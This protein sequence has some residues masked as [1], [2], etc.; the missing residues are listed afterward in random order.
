[1]GSLRKMFKTRLPALATLWSASG[2]PG[3]AEE[4]DDP[5][6]AAELHSVTTHS[7]TS[8]G[9]EPTYGRAGKQPD[10][11]Y[12]LMRECPEIIEEVVERRYN[13]GTIV[14]PHL[15]HGLRRLSVQDVFE[16]GSLDARHADAESTE[17]GGGVDTAGA[18]SDEGRDR[19]GESTSDSGLSSGKGSDAGD[20]YAV[21]KSETYEVPRAAVTQPPAED[22]GSGSEG[23]PNGAETENWS[24][25]SVGEPSSDSDGANGGA[26]L[27]GC[28][29]ECLR[30]PPDENVYL[31][32]KTVEEIE[33]DRQNMLNG[34]TSQVAEGNS[35]YSGGVGQSFFL[36][37]P[38]TSGGETYSG[39]LSALPHKARSL[40]N[41]QQ[42]FI[43]VHN[44]E[45]LAVPS[46]D[47]KTHTR[48]KPNKKRDR[49]SKS[50][51]AAINQSINDNFVLRPSKQFET[52]GHG[53]RSSLSFR[54]SLY[55]TTATWDADRQPWDGYSEL[56]CP[57][58]APED[59]AEEEPLPSSR[60]S[61]LER[62]YERLPL[63]RHSTELQPSEPLYANSGELQQLLVQQLREQTQPAEPADQPDGPAPGMAHIAPRGKRRR[64]GRIT[65]PVDAA[66]ALET[67]PEHTETP[68]SPA[69][70]LLAL[71]T[72]DSKFA[73]VRIKPATRGR[74]T[75]R[76][77]SSMNDIGPVLFTPPPST[78]AHPAVHTRLPS[79]AES[80]DQQPLEEAPAAPAS[81][82]SAAPLWLTLG[83]LWVT[84]C[85]WAGA[86]GRALGR[87]TAPLS[88]WLGVKYMS[89]HR[90][91]PWLPDLVDQ[92]DL[93]YWIQRTKQGSNGF[94]ELRK[95]IKHGGDFCK[96][97]ASILQE[98]SDLEVTYARGLQKLAAKLLKASRDGLGS[99]NQAWQ[100]VGTEMEHQADIHKTLAVTY[101]EE[102]VKPLRGLLESQHK[103]RRTVETNVDK[104]A[105]NLA[106][107][108]SAEAKA[109][110]LS[111]QCARENERA[112]EQ[113]LEARLAHDSARK[114]AGKVESR[115][116]KT[117]NA[118]AKADTEYYNFCLRSERARLEWE[119]ALN[120]G[121][122]CFQRLEEERLTRLRAAL[123]A[124]HQSLAELAPKIAQSA[125]RLSEPVSGADVSQ[126][127]QT[128][129]QV[130]RPDQPAEQLLPDFYAEDMTNA[131]N[132]DRRKKA[133][134]QF[135]RLLEQDVGRERRGKSGVENLAKAMKESPQFS[136]ESSQKDVKEKLQHLRST[137][138]YLEAS[139]FKVQ[140]ALA[141]TEG[142]PRPQHP[143]SRHIQ[144][145]KDRQ[146][147][148]QSVLRVPNWVNLEPS[149]SSP[150]HSPAWSADRDRGTA[151]GTSQRPP[152]DSDELNTEDSPPEST[153]VSAVTSPP[154]A[155]PTCDPV[156]DPPEGAPCR[157]R[158]QA[159]YDYKANMNDELT[160]RAGDVIEVHDRQPDGWWLGELRGTIGIFPATYVRQ[161]I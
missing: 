35:S 97:L 148:V 58:P 48:S 90:N 34:G 19:T 109:K 129:L 101:T 114:D 117:E 130:K 125:S 62:G 46:T 91:H 69:E 30:D 47:R 138:A 104:T 15:R 76:K 72:K 79:A 135:A 20:T 1:M 94:E 160:I 40:Q 100:R 137:L 42:C 55:S 154:T 122:Q 127:V 27:D 7:P 49:S 14:R 105:K 44:T 85:G 70:A 50:P 74:G 131:M 22:P 108:R 36:H 110:K 116:Q 6:D 3:S 128:V 89:L 82:V 141:E 63:R 43:Q 29:V 5:G 25:D 112:E 53:V 77:S 59:R 37:Q 11:T 133:L 123:Q 161:L 146:G 52:Y 2:G 124:Y 26:E 9:A 8:E 23:R 156:K 38:E 153:S 158:Y 60:G 28:Y 24:C 103:A 140:A 73:C 111:Y 75:M 147:M 45:A 10:M 159:I 68:S 83:A 65:A 67:H 33:R 142:Q 4:D 113:A 13:T 31:E 106:E 115:R 99:V 12:E 120:K 21:P 88:G 96:E 93:D 149:D 32:P 126:D 107:W 143:L 39:R 87:A 41:L 95:Y 150:D 18:G 64:R 80:S 98:R 157:D 71:R 134:E 132:R 17:L 51:V 81:P 54:S 139:R 145:L 78:P 16:E 136:T 152:S 92:P 66:Q 86:A 151:D 57:P 119:T 144:Q 102:L 56:T 84:V 118:L 155:E 61:T 121:S